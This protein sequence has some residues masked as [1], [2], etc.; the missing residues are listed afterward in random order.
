MADPDTAKTILG[1]KPGPE[2]GFQV[3]TRKTGYEIVSKKDGSYSDTVGIYRSANPQ[4]PFVFTPAFDLPH[5][6][7][8]DQHY[9]ALGHPEAKLASGRL[10]VSV[11]RNHTIMTDGQPDPWATLRDMADHPDRYRPSWHEVEAS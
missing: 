3:I 6:T 11:S 10:L 9:L 1:P 2:S 8:E 4:G 7:Q 5:W